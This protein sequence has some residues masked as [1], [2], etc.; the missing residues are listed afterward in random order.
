MLAPRW[1]MGNRVSSGGQVVPELFRSRGS[2]YGCAHKLQ[3]VVKKKCERNPLG[4]ERSVSGGNGTSL[5][6]EAEGDRKR[7]GQ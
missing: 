5:S 2:I 6:A 3:N 7:D 4:R 1:A